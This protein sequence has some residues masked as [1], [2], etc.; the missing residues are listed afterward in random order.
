MKIKVFF[1]VVLVLMGLT[2]CSPVSGPEKGSIAP[3]F[4]LP[5]MG[6]QA[7]SF[8]LSKTVET[9]PLLIVFW[10]TWCPSC[11]DEIPQLNEWHEQLAAKG[12]KIYGINVGE[13]AQEI[14]AFMQA[15]PILYPVL[16]DTESRVAARYGLAGLP[17]AVLLAKGGKILYYGF[18]LPPDPGALLDEESPR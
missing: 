7:E 10:A 9:Q 5:V 17:A 14:K 3:D 1:P 12:L 13:S 6:E 18:S 2:G 8:T 4:T 11:V 16:L 15:Q